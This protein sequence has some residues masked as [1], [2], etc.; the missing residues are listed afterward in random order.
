MLENLRTNKRNFLTI[1]F[2]LAIGFVFAV[3]FGPG[4]LS[5]GGG[6]GGGGTSHVASVNGTAIA[7]GEFERQYERRLQLLQG[8]LGGAFTRD[9]AQQLGVPKI[10]LD[11]VV[12]RELLAQEAERRGVVVTDEEISQAVHSDPGFHEG[13]RFSFPLYQKTVGRTYGSTGRYEDLLR[14]DLLASKM[15]TLILSAVK[16]SDAEVK[17]AWQA[18]ADRLELAFVRFPAAAAAKQVQVTDA[19]VKDFAAKNAERIDRFYDEN[20]GRFDQP[21]RVRARH[22][23]AR[24]ATGADAEAEAAKRKIEAAAERVKKGE[25][26]AKVAGELSEDENTKGRGGD[27]GFVTENLVE[28]PFADAAFA[29]EQGKVSDP[30]RT[31]TGWHLIQVDEVV[32]AKKV[33][34]EDA[35]PEI[36]RELLVQD[37]AQTL[38][39]ERAQAALAAAKGGK[40]LVDLFPA[41]GAKQVTF[42][43]E[44]ITVQE[45]GSFAASTPTIPNLGAAPKL[46]ADTVSAKAGTLLPEVY[47]AAGG[48]VVALV[49]ARDLPDAARFD[50]QK[51]PVETRLRNRKETQVFTALLDQL[52]KDAKV[53]VNEQYFGRLAPAQAQN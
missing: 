10:A 41:G 45:T 36:A 31:S 17:T 32:P 48:A 22:I 28:K 9:I 13:G 44:P 27:L 6:F 51:S 2:V 7:A 50:E 20:A 11:D 49:K 14:R 5:K 19:E 39:R 18:E 34:K 4:S 26:F 25:D 29:L 16:V 1:A 24:A 43:G 3:N 46:L 33:S 12:H 47:D 40:S 35:R 53:E 30:V 37:R 23:L 52:R 15:Q 21:K 42:G 38:A 8:Q